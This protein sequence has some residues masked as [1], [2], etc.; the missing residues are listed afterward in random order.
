M[1]LLQ[2]RH[3]TMRIATLFSRKT[4]RRWAACALAVALLGAG[5]SAAADRSLR[6]PD[7]GEVRALVI[8][9]DAYRHVRTL[10]GAAA[11]ARDL[12]GALRNSGARDVTAL[13]DEQVSRAAVMAAVDGLIARSGPHDLVVFTLAGHGTQEPE[14]EK[15]SHPDGMEDVFL[16]PGFAVSP[17]GS[18]ERIFG[19]EFN[20]LIKQIELRGARVLFVADTCY[21]GGMVREVDPRAGEMSFR[22]A[23]SYRLAVDLLQPIATSSEARL[24]ELDFDRTAFLAAVDHRTKAPEV[25]IPGVPGLRGALSYAVAR[26]VEGGAD[27][28]GDGRTTLKELF[29]NVRQ[30]VYQLSDQRQNIVATTPPSLDPNKDVVFELARAVNIVAAPT[31]SIP[32]ASPPSPAATVP[33]SDSER[34]VRIA[35][36]DGNGARLAGLAHHDATFEVVRPADNPDLIWDPV[37]RDVVAWGDVIAYRVDLPDLPSIIDRAAAIRELKRIAVKVPQSLKV[38][39]NDGL[40]RKDSLVQ[41]EVSDVAE[42]AL[43]LFNIAGDGTVQLL[44][45]L[46]SNSPILHE[47]EF[48]FPVRVR[49]PLGSDQLVA[50]TSQRRMPDLEQAVLRMNRK[51]SALQMV[52]MLRQH[53]PNDAR[54]GSAGVFTAP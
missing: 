10:K 12:A 24:T 25:Q 7:G 4:P 23:P 32:T 45:P 19:S 39:P 1:T 34:P 5:P 3:R 26:A 18:L 35:S 37:S 15:G 2:S 36:L 50:V 41:L 14:R 6:S 52:R 47:P 21:G 49:T 20:H 9:I 44:Y 31:I 8:G 53:A 11:D 38:M 30:V 27:A 43:I 13:I 33:R 28:D 16:L 46:A 17:A 22:Q 48:R 40:Y 29:T 51:R 42:R 54:I